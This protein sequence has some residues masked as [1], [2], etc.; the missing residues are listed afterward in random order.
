ML[1][2]VGGIGRR[3][4]LRTRSNESWAPV[5]SNLTGQVKSA[6]R[7]GVGVQVPHRAPKYTG[8]SFNG[9]TE[10]FESSDVGSIPAPPAK[11]PRNPMAEVVDFEDDWLL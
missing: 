9:R 4:R 2:P 11:C 6:I 8:G 1:C 7:E 10:D 5:S 3:S